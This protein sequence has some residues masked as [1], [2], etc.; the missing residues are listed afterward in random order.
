M[1]K[2]WSKIKIA[3]DLSK[4]EGHK[5]NGNTRAQL[6]PIKAYQKTPE[7]TPESRKSVKSQ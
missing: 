4:R 5:A 6:C 1:T 7:I 2:E 3:A